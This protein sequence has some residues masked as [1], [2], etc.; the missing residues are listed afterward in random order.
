MSFKTLGPSWARI[1][2]ILCAAFLL[3]YTFCLPRRLFD[4]PLSAT[5]YSS[6]G[7]LLGAR[8]SA[9]GQWYFAPSDSVPDKFAEC[10]VTYEDK[11]FRTHSGVD[12]L[13]VGRAVFQNISSARVVSG[14]STITMQVIRMSRR[15]APRTFGEK[16][17]EAF[18]ATRLELRCS[19]DDILILYA[20]NAPFG[21]NVIG[22]EAAA[23]RYY[24]RSPEDLSWGESALL[25]VLPNSPGLIHPGR[26]R[27]ALLSKRNALLDRLLRS[28]AIDSLECEL[29]KEE[30]LPDRPLPMPDLAYHLLERCRLEG[31]DGAYVTTVDFDLQN[32]VNSIAGR[33][34]PSNHSNLVDNMSVLVTEVGSGKVLAYYGNTRSCQP[35]VRGG[36]VDMVPAMRSSGSTLKPLL[37]AAMLQKGMIYPGTLIKDTPYNSHNFSPHNYS[38][39][40]EGAVPASSVVSRSLNVPSVRMLEDYGV[41]NFLDVLHGVGLGEIDGTAEHYGLSLILGGAEVSL[42]GLSLAYNRMASLLA[43]DALPERLVCLETAERGHLDAGDFPFGR[44]AAWLSF[45]AVSRSSRPE[46]EASWMEFDSSERIAWKTGTSWGNR[47]AWSIGATRN[48]VVA[49]W[50]GNS[51]GEGRSGMTGVNSA[52]PVMFDVFSCL[53]RSEWFDMPQDEMKMVEVCRESGLP[54]GLLCPETDA[55]W[56]PDV[57]SSPQT[58]P[59]HV[60]VHLSPDGL[61]QVN[62]ACCDPT[63]MRHEV[64]FVLPPV[65]EWYYMRGHADYEQL[66]PK[67]PDY[68]ASISSDSSI[69]IVYPRDGFVVIPTRG[70]AGGEKRGIVCRAAH[71]SASAVLYWH[72]DGEYLGETVGEHRMLVSLTPGKHRLTVVDVDGA[73]AAVDFS[74]R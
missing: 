10:L 33:Y 69:E 11:R 70:L 23:W 48:Y 3:W 51:D 30:P 12:L 22:L 63:L 65:Q 57:S 59:Y 8:A 52:A 53:P 40:F 54:A 21:G 46:E 5:L 73:R 9:A 43:G 41:G 1:S 44:A 13:S 6:D 56:V 39:G 66:P 27:E 72:L 14:A 18:L 38:K 45:E 20:S 7:R 55:V 37:Y 25:A 47:D 50:V 64:R 58:C 4:E 49:V 62:S 2:L 24:G 68:D 61:Y 29:S 42:Q 26:N 31:G 34:F 28:G 17:Y 19:K 67:H 15:D 35:S 74:S 32:K 36:S 60:L 16:V 71:S